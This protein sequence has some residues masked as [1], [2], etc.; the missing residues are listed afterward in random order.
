MVEKT[1]STQDK[2][3]SRHTSES[4]SNLISYLRSEGE[5]RSEIRE[6]R[7]NHGN[8]DFPVRPGVPYI[9]QSEIQVAHL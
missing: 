2:Q 5:A 4:T 7:R 8:F 9:S 3:S 1:V 6:V